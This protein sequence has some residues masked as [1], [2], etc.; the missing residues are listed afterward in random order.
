MLVRLL[1]GALDLIGSSGAAPPDL[2]LGQQGETLA[3]WYLRE[4]GFTM[5]ARNYHR[6]GGGGEV[7]LIGWEG[8]TLVFVEVKT[9]AS[10]QVRSA[11]DAV[12]A[13]KRRRLVDAARDY[14]YR[15]RASA[16]YRF[17]VVSIHLQQSGDPAVHH[18]RNA[19][20]EDQASG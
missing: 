19:F 6:S 5:V 9:R 4:Q 20:T 18:F 10:A 3:Y 1:R 15:A 13:E 16:P 12:D 2:P 7:D 8:E 14:R 11:E 17:D